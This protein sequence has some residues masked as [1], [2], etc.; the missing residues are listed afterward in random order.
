MS[1]HGTE[2]DLPIW[3]TIFIFDLQKWQTHVDKLL[4]KEI[5]KYNY[6]LESIELPNGID[7][8]RKKLKKD[9][10]KRFYIIF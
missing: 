1:E 9:I 3:G 8:E 5:N 7:Y 6:K 2:A 10:T 4:I